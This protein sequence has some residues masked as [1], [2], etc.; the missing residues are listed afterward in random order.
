MTV[1]I[2]G[3]GPAGMA[4]VDGLVDA[5]VGNFVVLDKAPVLGGLAQTSKWEGVGDHDLGPH[6]IF[7]LD[8]TLVARVERLLPP[9]RW[10]TRNKVSSIFIKGHFLPY[11]P[12]PFS[13]AGVFGLVAFSQMVSG[14]GFAKL[15][16]LLYRVSPKTFEEDLQGRLGK[17]LYHILFKPIAEKLWG[18][19]KELDVKLSKGRVQ[20]PSLLEV[21]GRL[22][23]LKSNSNFEALTF[24]YPKAGLGSLWQSIERKSKG[25]GEFLLNHTVSGI[26][27][28]NKTVKSISI[29]DKSG[30]VRVFELAP[31]DLVVSTLPLM[32]TADLLGEALS[33]SIKAVAQ[34]VIALNDLLLVFLHVDTPSLLEESWVFVPDPDIAFHRVSEQESFD[35]EMTQNGSIVCCEIM[36]SDKRPMA[37]K[38]DAELVTLAENG[39]ADMGYG[40]FNVLNRRVIRLPKSYPV[41]RAGFEPGLKKLISEL[42]ELENFKSIGRQGAFNY[43][44]TL[45]AMDIGYGYAKWVSEGVKDSWGSERERTNHYPV[46]D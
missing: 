43:I 19:P 12:S 18:N 8:Q 4:V 31:E 30:Q 22:L 25:H 20:T 17:P 10:L 5:N 32:L 34:K 13:L 28:E 44:G 14:Y 38:S 23:K 6:K 26:T 7:S 45:D 16:S 33:P 11:P 2:L 1:Y 35:P 9:E 21:L 36:S 42:D 46:L 24:R 29:R 27:I 15:K 39:L 3:A 37:E 40:G 41:F